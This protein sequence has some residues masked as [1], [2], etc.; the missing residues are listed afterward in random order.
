MIVS[1]R[2]ARLTPLSIVRAGC[3]RILVDDSHNTLVWGPCETRVL[4]LGASVEQLLALPPCS[5]ITT[6]TTAPG[7]K[8]Y[9]ALAMERQLWRGLRSFPRSSS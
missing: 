1:T 2:T 3:R 5:S 7:R 6:R 4:A 8:A 9:F